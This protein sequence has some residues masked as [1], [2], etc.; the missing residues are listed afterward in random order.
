MEAYVTPL[1]AAVAVLI[2]AEGW[3]V[4]SARK[5]ST[6]SPSAS[7]KPSVSTAYAALE[8]LEAWGVGRDESYGRGLRLVRD[9]WLSEAEG[10][11]GSAL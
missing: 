10:D 5:P 7:P 4:W 9:H 11:D 2:A 8:T 3:K 6:P 1:L